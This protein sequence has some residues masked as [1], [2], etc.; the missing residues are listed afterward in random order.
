MPLPK[1]T[2]E[3]TEEE[4]IS[5]CM[6]NDVMNSEYPDRDQRYAV[7]NS[8]LGGKSNMDIE[9]KGIKVDLKDSKDGSFV[10]RIAT[11]NVRDKDN[12]ITRP[13][14]FTEGKTVLVSAYMHGSWQGRLP[15]GKATIHE[16]G[17]EAIAEGQFNLNTT[18]GRDTYEAVKFAPE[19]QEWSYGFYPELTEEGKGEEAGARILV[20]V[21][22]KEISPVLAGAGVNTAVLAIKNQKQGNVQALIDS[23]GSWAGSFTGCVEVLSGKPG[24]TEPEALCAWLHHEAE[25]VWPSEKEKNL[26]EGMTYAEQAEAVLAAVTDL[27][28]R[29]KSLADLRLKESRALSST[30]RTR[31]QEVA[32]AL[33]KVKADLNVLLTATEPRDDNTLAQA[34]MLY[35]KIKNQLLEVT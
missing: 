5:R 28:D 33:V 27:A 19:L 24:I 6:A 11:L 29:T 10:A 21:T 17:N 34:V 30:N 31:I 2:S 26:S 22:E 7:C 32:D 1:P 9:R 23:W 20:K 18:E 12:D 14:A 8:L 15:V 16:V 3:E 35:I 4:F 13:G 25:G